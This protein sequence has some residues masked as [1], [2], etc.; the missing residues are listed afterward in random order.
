MVFRRLSA[1]ALALAFL[2]GC[3]MNALTALCSRGRTNRFRAQVESLE[4]RCCP[5]VAGPFSITGTT[6][7]IT[8]GAN[9]VLVRYEGVSVDPL[10]HLEHGHIY[11]TVGS[12]TLD[13]PE[14]DNVIVSSAAGTQAV[15]FR[16]DSPLVTPFTLQLNLG[17]GNTSDLDFSAGIQGVGESINI[18]GGGSNTVTSRFGA[19]S[20][21]TAQNGLIF[22][23][24]L[25]D[26]YN[27]FVSDLNGNLT[28]AGV[29]YTVIGGND[30]NFIAVNAGAASYAGGG[31]YVPLRSIT[32]DQNSIVGLD[33]RGGLGNDTITTQFV[34]T[35][36]GKYGRLIT[37]YDGAGNQS[38]LGAT[39]I[40]LPGSTGIYH[41]A[42]RG[43]AGR[44]SIS[45][46]LSEPP[47]GGAGSLQ[48]LVCWV[49]TETGH[50]SVTVSPG[51]QVYHDGDNPGIQN[52]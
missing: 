49:D 23:A 26:G 30:G 13:A 51:V 43:G 35:L 6:L 19:V 21:N 34:G 10:S 44:D 5:T 3:L 17:A 38:E 11:A 14:I 8:G 42:I 20:N 52:F 33:L 29:N 2:G 28:N 12:T 15:N 9:A 48:S 37:G 24:A 31:T 39:D 1:R 36:L 50:G 18:T 27:T 4:D 22:K 41:G 47:Q 40:L 25:G 32:I 46:Y 16:L 45:Q 7:T